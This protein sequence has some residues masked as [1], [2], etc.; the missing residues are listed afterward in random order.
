ME[1]PFGIRRIT[2]PLPTRPG[3]VHSYLLP[4]EDGRTSSWDQAAGHAGGLAGVARGRQWPDLRHAFHPDHVGAADVAER[5]GRRCTGAALDYAQCRLVWGTPTGRSGSPAGFAPASRMNHRGLI[6][7][8]DVYG[9]FIISARRSCRRRRPLDPLGARRRAG[10][11]RRS[12]LPAEGARARLGRP[13]ARPDLTV[14]LWRRWARSA[15][16]HPRVARADDQ[17]APGSRSPATAIDPDPVGRA[18]ELIEHHHRRLAFAE[19]AL[20][21]APRTG[22]GSRSTSSAPS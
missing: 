20:T 4:G 16:R 18:R 3:H 6:R 9:P 17:L 8:G 19:A 15:R 13:P 11:R 21:A 2:T 10:P 22:C 1:L 12:A 5:P 14:G 7:S